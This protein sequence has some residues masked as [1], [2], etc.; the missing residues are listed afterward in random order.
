MLG[1][2]RVGITEAATALQKR[3]LIEYRRGQIVIL[4]GPGL[5]KSACGCYQEAN[6]LY[7][8]T[9]GTQLKSRRVTLQ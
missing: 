8:Q 6:H 5:E 4:N 1:V 2:R 3:G 9:M 7:D